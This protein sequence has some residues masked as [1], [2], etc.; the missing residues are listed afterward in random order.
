MPCVLPEAD[1]EGGTEVAEEDPPAFGRDGLAGRPYFV[2]ADV[3]VL[4]ESDEEGLR[5]PDAGPDAEPAPAALEAGLTFG[6]GV[7]PRD[8]EPFEPGWKGIAEALSLDEE[9]RGGG[10]E[11][12]TSILSSLADSGRRSAITSEAIGPIREKKAARS[13]AV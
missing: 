13:W 2:V 12:S 4:E 6:A 10:L 8:D 7:P 1:R 5:E 9:G 3:P 11:S